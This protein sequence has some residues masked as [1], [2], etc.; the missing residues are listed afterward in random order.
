MANYKYIMLITDESVGD[1]P[2]IADVININRSKPRLFTG[3]DDWVNNDNILC[4]NCTLDFN[5]KPIF[6]PMFIRGMEKDIQHGDGNKISENLVKMGVSGHLCSFACAYKYVID[7]NID[8]WNSLERLKCLYYHFYCRRVIKIEPAPNKEEMTQY[9][10]QLS[11]EKYRHALNDAEKKTADSE[12][13]RV[14]VPK[15]VHSLWHLY[16]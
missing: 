13:Q 7:H 3:I 2:P 5:N 12:L 4:H 8:I 6:I 9:G 10:G 16:N 1:E 14:V 15:F 11:I